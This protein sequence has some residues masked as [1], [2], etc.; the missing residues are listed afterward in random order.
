M[1]RAIVLALIALL[2]LAQLLASG[3]PETT[4]AAGQ[5]TYTWVRYVDGPVDANS[6]AEQK[7]KQ[8]Y[9]NVTIN[10][11]GLQ[12][13]TFYEQLNTKLAGGEKF[14]MI[15]EWD[16]AHVRSHVEQG[17]L[18]EVPYD[19]L[20]KY[21]PKY[22]KVQKD[23]GREV[24]LASYVDGKNYGVPSVN[25]SQTFPFTDGIRLDWLRNVGLSDKL[26]DILSIAELEEDA[27][28][29]EEVD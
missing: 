11:V 8:L 26:P 15:H 22:F 16:N 12:R 23:F 6:Y 25:E 14:D 24:F 13:P 19:W 5:E 28:A 4:A 10:V 18:A 20:K 3:A 17:V 7:F 21:T 27:D 2:P 29:I 1:K 9:P